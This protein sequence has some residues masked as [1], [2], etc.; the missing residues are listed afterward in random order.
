MKLFLLQPTGKYRMQ[1]FV[2]DNKKHCAKMNQILQDMH[3]YIV[4]AVNEACE[5]TREQLNSP[6]KI[7]GKSDKGPLD[8]MI[9]HYKRTHST[10]NANALE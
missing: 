3:N 4:V 7:R 8:A 6:E 5:K 1:H 9:A 10:I 2:E